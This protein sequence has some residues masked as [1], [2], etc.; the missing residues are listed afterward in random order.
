MS[1]RLQKLWVALIATLWIVCFVAL[2]FSGELMRTS[3]TMVFGGGLVLGQL[4]KLLHRHE[5]YHRATLGLAL[6]ASLVMLVGIILLVV[7]KTEYRFIMLFF[8]SLCLA[9]IFLLA[10]RCAWVWPSPA[11]RQ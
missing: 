6:A 8:P 4:A 9:D 7:L 5:G 3:A 2:L 1:I 10:V 11:L